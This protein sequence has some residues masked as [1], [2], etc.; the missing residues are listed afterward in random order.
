MSRLPEDWEDDES[1]D[2][3]ARYF[4]P[5]APIILNQVE[6]RR[7]INSLA[8]NPGQSL[9]LASVEDPPKRWT[10]CRISNWPSNVS[11][12]IQVQLSICGATGLIVMPQER[13]ITLHRP[14]G[15]QV[16]IEFL[17]VLQALQDFDPRIK[18]E[19]S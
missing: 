16:T 11:L 3:P 7:R 2:D 1:D 18:V 8:A 17:A 4:E 12:D 9:L 15:W 5:I 13:G 10:T 19:F 14:K 6:L